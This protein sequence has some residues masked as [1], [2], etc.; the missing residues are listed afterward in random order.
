ML[1]KISF[2]A[3]QHMASATREAKAHLGRASRLAAHQYIGGISALDDKCITLPPLPAPTYNEGRSAARGRQVVSRGASDGGG[4]AGRHRNAERRRSGLPCKIF[5][6]THTPACT[7]T[8]HRTHTRTPLHA[9]WRKRPMVKHQRR[10]VSV[11]TLET[12]IEAERRQLIF[13]NRT[14]TW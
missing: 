14:S 11:P 8:A 7:Y 5:T 13:G 3:H 1:S 2:L 12:R 10:G 6:T 4:I 9:W